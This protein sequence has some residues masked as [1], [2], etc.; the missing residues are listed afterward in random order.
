[1]TQVASRANIYRAWLDLLAK[2]RSV[3]MSFA[4]SLQPVVAGIVACACSLRIGQDGS[5]V[6]CR[7]FGI[8]ISN[9]ISPQ[10]TLKE[11]DG[12]AYGVT[13]EVPK[14]HAMLATVVEVGLD[15]DPQILHHLLASLL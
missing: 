11:V 12:P 15:R 14:N 13:A 3:E 10:R 7:P 8:S 5:T 4:W 2:D 6:A 9:H 1:M